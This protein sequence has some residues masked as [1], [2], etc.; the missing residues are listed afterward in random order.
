MQQL[1]SPYHLINKMNRQFCTWHLSP[2]YGILNN[3]A[4]YLD[5][6]DKNV[7]KAKGSIWEKPT[8]TKETHLPLSREDNISPNSELFPF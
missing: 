6:K 3:V 7:S 2:Y 8:F 5:V 4:E 1:L